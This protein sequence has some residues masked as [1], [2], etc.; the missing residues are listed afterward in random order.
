[1]DF[2]HYLV[3]K[4]FEVEVLEPIGFD[5]SNFVIDQSNYARDI[6]TFNDKIDFIFYDEKGDELVP[7]RMLNNGVLLSHQESGLRFLL[8]EK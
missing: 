8:E 7:S 3:F 2:S 5:A 6:F 1:M 4:D